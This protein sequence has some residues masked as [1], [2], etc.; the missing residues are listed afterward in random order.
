MVGVEQLSAGL[1]LPPSLPPKKGLSSLSLRFRD[2]GF[3]EKVSENVTEEL[4]LSRN[5]DTGE[6]VMGLLSAA[7]ASSGSLAH[8]RSLLLF[9]NRIGDEGMQVFATDVVGS[10]AK[11]T[12]LDL[13][14]AEFGDEGMKALASAVGRGTMTKLQ[15]L[16]LSFNE[17]GDA[18]VSAFADGCADN[19][20]TK[21]ETLL[22]TDN[23]IGD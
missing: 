19:A 3:L 20:L 13:R 9:D 11:L 1:E 14:Q 8:V 17:I 10:L 6:D 18:G 21:L 2:K 16:N 22:L 5:R 15:E 7:V 4:D 23:Q 12:W